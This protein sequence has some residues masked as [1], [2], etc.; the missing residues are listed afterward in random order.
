MGPVGDAYDNARCESFLATLECERLERRRFAS[1][2]E[3][4]MA[5][6]IFIEGFDNPARRHAALGYRSPICHE[7]EMQTDRNSATP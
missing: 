6:F 3:A 1:Q 5:C 7:Q 4:R 2:I